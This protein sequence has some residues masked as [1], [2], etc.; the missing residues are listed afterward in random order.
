MEQTLDP[1]ERPP[2]SWSTTLAVLNRNNVP[3]SD[4]RI[5]ECRAALAYWRVRR[6]ID[7]ERDG[8]RPEYVPALADMLRYAHSAVSA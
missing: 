7:K 8:L 3:D 6:V 5:A 4:P 2:I 1:G